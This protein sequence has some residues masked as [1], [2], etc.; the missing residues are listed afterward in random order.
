[1]EE[2]LGTHCNPEEAFL[3]DF[4][5]AFVKFAE[6]ADES[7]PLTR[8]AFGF[9]ASGS[10]VVFTL[11]PV[12]TVETLE[13]PVAIEAARSVRSRRYV[14]YVRQPIDIPFPDQRY[15]RCFCYV[16]SQGLPKDTIIDEDMCVAVSP[17]THPTGRP[18]LTPSPPL[19]W[20]DLYLHSTSVFMLRLKTVDGEINHSLSPT[21]SLGQYLDVRE[22]TSADVMRKQSQDAAKKIVQDFPESSLPHPSYHAAESEPDTHPSRVSIEN[23]TLAAFPPQAGDPTRTDVV[24]TA[25]AASIYSSGDGSDDSSFHSGAPSW[26]PPVLFSGEEDPRHQFVPVA[27]FD[28]DISIVEEFANASLLWDEVTEIE[29]II[30]ESQRRCRALEQSNREHANEEREDQ[31]RIEALSP[32]E[33][34]FHIHANALS[35]PSCPSSGNTT[36]WFQTKSI[37]GFD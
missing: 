17:A 6:P 31:D 12:A 36:R 9:P 33:S 15:Q 24:A 11:D 37:A 32:A 27:T 26:L 20:T 21:L 3:K 10:F 22:Y 34:D 35:P 30:A 19:P 8:T 1:M 18:T 29:R 14:G 16:L 13:D 25:E 5:N 23:A 4:Q 28:L 2:A 7:V